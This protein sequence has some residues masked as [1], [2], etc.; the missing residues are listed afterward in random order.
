[1]HSTYFF[2]SSS[3]TRFVLFFLYSNILF[4][5]LFFLSAFLASQFIKEDECRGREEQ[6][7][8]DER[9]GSGVSESSWWALN[10][11]ALEAEEGVG[12]EV[13]YHPIATTVLEV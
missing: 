12:E 5:V 10:K 1:L 4:Y 13:F 11:D 8:E 6:R 7:D 3:C 9:W 2:I